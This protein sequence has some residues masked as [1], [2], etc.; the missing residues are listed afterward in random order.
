MV[1]MRNP[2]GK[3]AF[4]ILR[5]NGE[6]VDEGVA[7]ELL[8]ANLLSLFLSSLISSCTGENTS[9]SFFFEDTDVRLASR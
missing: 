7:S 8:V 2:T 5:L 3:D 4:W 6:L 9:M 1:G